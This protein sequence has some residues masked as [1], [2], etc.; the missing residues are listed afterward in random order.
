MLIEKR[1]PSSTE[2]PLEILISSQQIVILP[3]DETELPEI[4]TD[5]SDFIDNVPPSDTIR[6]LPHSALSTVFIATSAPLPILTDVEANQRCASRTTNLLTQS[7]S[8]WLSQFRDTIGRKPV[9]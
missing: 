2:N 9:L 1:L 5:L 4:L 6:D 8:D 3:P 7:V